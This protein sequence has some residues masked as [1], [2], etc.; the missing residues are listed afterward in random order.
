MFT[1]I[2]EELGTIIS[3]QDGKITIGA[4][5]VL[6]ETQ[7]GSS[8]AVNGVCLTVT[9]LT[10]DSFT[11]DVMPETLRRSNLGRLSAG[12]RVNLERAMPLG[13]RLGGHLIQGHIDAVGRTTALVP[14]G[15]AVIA[16]FE[17]PAE[18]MYYIVQKGFIA[19]DGISLTVSGRNEVSFQ[20]SVVG[21]TRQHTTLNERRVGDPVNLEV[22]I[23]AKYVR[24]FSQARGP[25]ITTDFLKEH[26]FLAG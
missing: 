25:G 12:D 18:V 22:D 8:L 13:G 21:Y 6:A 15:E 11:V 24:Q 4:R 1:G 17:A 10:P 7:T 2:V 16:R 26:G 19:V 9:T 20:V 14:E 5:E 23:I 3:A